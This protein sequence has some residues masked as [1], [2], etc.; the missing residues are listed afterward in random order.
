MIHR[1][2]KARMIYLVKLFQ[3]LP[4]KYQTEKKKEETKLEIQ[5][6]LSQAKKPD[7]FH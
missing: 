6:L 5:I 7:N 4:V 2:V 3:N 1:K